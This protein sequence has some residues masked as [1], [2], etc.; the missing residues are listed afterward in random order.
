MTNVA[1]TRLFAEVQAADLGVLEH[2]HAAAAKLDSPELH[3]TAVLSGGQ[4]KGGDV[5]QLV[6]PAV[7]KALRKKFGK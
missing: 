1:G 5:S 6:H 4:P 2:L 7:Q 3:D